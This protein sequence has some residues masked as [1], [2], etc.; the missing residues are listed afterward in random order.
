MIASLMMYARPEL[1]VALSAYWRCIR[2]RLAERGIASPETL[3]QTTAEF[4][5]WED[6]G[7]VLS[8][9]CGMPYRTRLHSSVQ[10]VGTPDYAL[11]G[12]PAGYYCSAIVVRADD[13]REDLRAFSN[14]RMV[15]N[16]AHSQSGFA[17]FYTHA[18]AAGFWFASRVKSDGH[19]NS[20]RMIA[21]GTADIAAID[22]QTWRLIQR[23]EPWANKL[24]VLEYT[25]ATPGLPYI[26]GPQQ[27]ATAVSEAVRESINDLSAEDRSMLDLNG[28]VT[29]PKSAYM[30]IPNP[31]IEARL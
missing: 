28:L 9:T 4:D 2:A 23:Y 3:S 30:A 27:N 31:P 26:S 1:D 10:L 5:V 14:A 17:A 15:F 7:L 19:V 29:I 16:M 8:Q 11:E 12:M 6:P 22:A 13:P 24:R 18:K 21:Q 20:A 25:T